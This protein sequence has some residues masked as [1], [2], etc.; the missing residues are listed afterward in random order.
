VAQLA[1]TILAA[2][3]DEQRA[4][5]TAV[6]GPVCVIAGAGT[7]KTRAITHRLAYAVDIGVIEPQKVLALTFTA[8]AAGEM[9]TRLRA[10]GV[11]GISARTFHAAALRQLMYFWPEVLGGRFPQ[12]LTTKTGFITEAINRAG[13]TAV[14]NNSILR[15]LAG[16]IEWSKVIGFAPDEYQ[17][18]SDDYSRQVLSGGQ[19][20]NSGDIAKIYEAYESLKRQE[21]AID[22]EDVLLLTVGM[23][24]EDRDVRD[25]VRDQYRYFTVDEYQDVSPLQQRLLDLWVGG[26]KDICV[27][28]DPAQTIY[29]FA[30]ATPAFLLNFTNRYPD[31][32]VIRL[33]RGYRSSPEII[34]TANAILRGALQSHELT[35][36]NSHGERPAIILAESS[37]SEIE[38]IVQEIQ[39][40]LSSGAIPHEIAVLART[41]SQID[42]ME[43]ALNEAGIENQVRNAE[44]FFNRTEVR[45][46]MKVVR[47]A[48]VL[49][50]SSSDRSQGAATA[51]QGDWYA[52]L[53][54]ALQP[55][56]NSEYVRAFLQLGRE[57]VQEGVTSL[58][59]YLR[60]LEDRAEQNN[61]PTLPGVVL[62][63]LHAAKG[64]EWERVYLIGVSEGLLPFGVTKSAPAISARESSRDS[65][66]TIEEE[67]RLF[68]VG[69]TRAKNSLTVSYYGVPSRFL[70]ESGLIH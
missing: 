35:S 54:S 32:E 18:A 31:A 26:R 68:Y 51:A 33:N 28:G 13:V 69:I 1:E 2:L 19:R 21:R 48:S 17:R 37:K 25:R 56:G 61:P 20:V 62:S 44:R 34:N 39:K 22:F 57:L 43:Q 42:D 63:T 40:A 47:I 24:E 50:G 49:S 36:Q 11:P 38:N 30:G 16:E 14:K 60:E 10:L 8:R 4:V 66:N 52:D 6:R 45:D 55:F 65:T 29:S 5:A 9:R 46:L 27:V 59:G 64:L 53:K 70:A 41:N 58:R 3:D 12:L 67:R 7:G 15:D 23:L